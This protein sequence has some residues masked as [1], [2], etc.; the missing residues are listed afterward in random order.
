[1]NVEADQGRRD[2]CFHRP[3]AHKLPWW[4][5]LGRLPFGTVLLLGLPWYFVLIVATEEAWRAGEKIAMLMVAMATGAIVLVQLWHAARLVA[6]WRRGFEPV[7]IDAS[8]LAAPQQLPS[9]NTVEVPLGEISRIRLVHHGC[10][11]VVHVEYGRRRLC[12]PDSQFASEDALADFL[13][14]LSQATGLPIERHRQRFGQFSLGTLLL[15]TGVVALVLGLNS[16]IHLGGETVGL[17][18]WRGLLLLA[19]FSPLV[20]LLWTLPRVGRT[21]ASHL[22]GVAY[23][24]GC[25][26][27]LLASFYVLRYVSGPHTPPG[28]QLHAWYPLTFP[29]TRLASWFVPPGYILRPAHFLPVAA[30]ISGTLLGIAGLYGWRAIRQWHGRPLIATLKGALDRAS[31]H[32]LATGGPS[33]GR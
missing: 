9:L 27:E 17:L 29:L 33:D 15:M 28:D 12:L 11:V 24:I 23:T 5:F 13:D 16:S 2:N 22:F 8:L 30:V 26:W 32:G 19:G 3:F 18:W 14:T 4:E 7:T 25:V 20:V 10:E 6:R 1:M 31:E 21:T